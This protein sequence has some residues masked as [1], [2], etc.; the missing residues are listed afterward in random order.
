MVIKDLKRR[1]T[2]KQEN[3]CLKEKKLCGLCKKAMMFKGNVL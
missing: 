3:L 2:L 1:D